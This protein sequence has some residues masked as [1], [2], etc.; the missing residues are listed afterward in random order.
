[1]SRDDRSKLIA[2]QGMISKEKIKSILILVD[3][4]GPLWG[5]SRSEGRERVHRTNS[6]NS[7]SEAARNLCEHYKVF[8]LEIKP[9]LSPK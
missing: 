9:S 2:H 3:S 6:V 8:A 5:S 1:M 4:G 7:A